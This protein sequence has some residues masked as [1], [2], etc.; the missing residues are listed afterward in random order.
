MLPGDFI[1]M[2]L[3]GEVTTSISALSEGVFWDF[4]QVNYPKMCLTID[5]G[6]SD[7]M[8]LSPSSNRQYLQP[9]ED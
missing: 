2:K 9:T 8:V 5:I 3:T 4:Q 6:L 1:A 7:I